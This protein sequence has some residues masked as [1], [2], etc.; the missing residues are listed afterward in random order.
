MAQNS[1]TDIVTNISGKVSLKAD[2]TEILAK[3]SVAEAEGGVD[4]SKVMTPYSTKAAIL[5]LAPKQD[6]KLDVLDIF[7]PVGTIYQSSDANF[8]PNTWGGTWVKIENRFLLGSGNKSVGSQGGEENVTLTLN[9][10]PSHQHNVGDIQIYGSINRD[11]SSNGYQFLADRATA[12]GAFGLPSNS[13]AYGVGD[14]R[15]GSWCYDYFDFY[16]SRNRSG[17]TAWTGGNGSHNNMPPYEVVNIWKR[18]A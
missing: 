2:K 9:Q 7:Y 17:N 14:S 12:S 1:L 3:A 4:D 6:I 5:K 11:T 13:N 10:I 18:T 16:A 15:V 8:N